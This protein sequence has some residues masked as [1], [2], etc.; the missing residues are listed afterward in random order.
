MQTHRRIFTNAFH[1]LV[2]SLILASPPTVLAQSGATT[3]KVAAPTSALSQRDIADTHD[4]LLKLLRLSPT[5]TSVVQRDPALLADREYVNR[6]NPELAQ[7]L[8][9]HPEVTRNPDFY[10]FTELN[11]DDGRRHEHLD[12]DA[13][14]ESSRSRTDDSTGRMLIRDGGPFV[15]F[16]FVVLALL[17]LIRAL[18]ENGRWKRAFQIQQDAHAKLIERFSSNQELLTYMDTDAGKRFLEA[19]PI[20]VSLAHDQ[21]VPNAVARVLTPLQI[22]VVLTLLG[23]GMMI[24]RYSLPAE[25][26]AGLLI[27]GVLALMPGIGLVLSAFLTWKLAGR[28]GLLSDAAATGP[29]E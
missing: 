10:L 18:L 26:A 5:L 25:Y 14:P 9:A 3:Q 8:D 12:R 15:M 17:W 21:R 22:G 20:A 19:A 13:W 7:F 24:L 1:S 6:S 11:G 29:R 2:A 28:L 23:I 16:F 4:E 27:T